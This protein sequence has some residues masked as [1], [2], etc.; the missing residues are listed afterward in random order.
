M[1]KIRF[2][3][4]KNKKILHLNFTKLKSEK[5]I[6]ALIRKAERLIS[7]Q[8]WESLLILTDVTGSRYTGKVATEIRDFVVHNKPYTKAGAVLGVTGIKYILFTAIVKFSKR[9]NLKAFESE[10]AAKDWLVKY[11]KKKAK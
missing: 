3:K 6:I 9:T 5:S 11:K 1:E 7:K 2:I 4:Y 10:E 8:P